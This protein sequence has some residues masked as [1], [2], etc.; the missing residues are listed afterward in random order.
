M[1][2]PD[3]PHDVPRGA[4]AVV[5]ALFALYHLG[6]ARERPKARRVAV[7][8][9]SAR[10]RRCD[11][12]GLGAAEPGLAPWR[13]GGLQRRRDA[14]LPLAIPLARGLMRDTQ[15]ARDVRPGVA[16]VV[17]WVEQAFKLHLTQGYVEGGHRSWRRGQGAVNCDPVARV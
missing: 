16:L 4:V 9:S 8:M 1:A 12:L 10:E 3:A 2:P 6:D 14:L 5:D 15:L 11:P 13:P 17:R 7:R